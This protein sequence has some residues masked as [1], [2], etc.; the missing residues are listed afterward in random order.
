MASVTQGTIHYPRA[1]LG[2]N[3]MKSTGTVAG[4]ECSWSAALVYPLLYMPWR[5]ASEL[6]GCNAAHV[7]RT[8]RCRFMAA[9]AAVEAHTQG[10]ISSLSQR[11]T[12]AQSFNLLL[13]VLMSCGMVSEG[14]VGHN[15]LAEA[16][17][18]HS[19]TT[20]CVA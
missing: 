3:L 14:E 18:L 16:H 6:P 12:L 15:G 2:S 8:C 13:W 9:G 7:Y 11:V 20:L 10:S 19:Y 5:D 1:G 4:M 17:Q